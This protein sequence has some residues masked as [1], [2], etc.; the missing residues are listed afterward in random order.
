MARTYCRSGG[1]AVLV[2]AAAIGLA[3]CTSGPSSP[4][5]ASLGSSG[6]APATGGSTAVSPAGNPTQLLDEWAACMRGHGDPSQADPT[7]DADKEIQIIMR[8][9]PAAVS[10]EAHDSTGP[11]SR[12]ELAA[13]A[14]LRGGQSPPRPPD[15]AAEVKYAE[16]M[17]SHGVPNYP[18]P[19]P[20]NPDETK[21]TGTGI[22]P[23][24]P[25]FLNADKLCDKQAG[26]PYVSPDAPD[27]G[28]VIV[29]S[30]NAP[31]GQL[32]GS[33]HAT[34]TASSGRP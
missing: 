18:D 25:F 26:I 29:R 30:I 4:P 10:A 3:A 22:D 7:I 23:N 9:V 12:Y 8:D 11:C 1:L 17:R 24:S 28:N 32:H 19:N 27:P 31:G 5:V 16:C 6:G 21:L 2:A 15:M 33:S 34:H 14:A 20:A 13:E